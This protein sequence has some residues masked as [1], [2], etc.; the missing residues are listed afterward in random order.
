MNSIIYNLKRTHIHFALFVLM[1]FAVTG[2][3][4]QDEP[5]DPRF[6]R[7]PQWY[8]DLKRDAPIMPSTVVTINDYDNFYLGVDFAEGHISE[9]PRN[10]MQYF[11]AF[12]INNTHHTENGHDWSTNNPSW[13]GGVW[14]DPVTAYDSLGNLYYENMYG[15]GTIQGCKVV[16]STDN[17]QTWGPPVIAI[18]GVD[19]NWIAADQTNGPYANYVYTVMTASSGG[20][21]TRSTDYGASFQ[22]MW[23]FP[24]QSLPGMMVAVGAHDNIQGG[25]VYVVTNGGSVSAST[26]TFY[27]SLN[28]GQ[29]FTQMSSQ[30]WAGY[31]GTFVNGRHSVQNMRTRPYPFIAADNSFG[32][33]RGRLYCVYATNDPP[34]SGNKPDILSRYSDDGG[35]T[36]SAAVRVNDDANTQ[37]HHQW[38]PAIWCDKDNGKLYVQWMDT[39]DTPNSDSCYIYATY[40]DDGG[41][42]F[43]TNQRISNEKMKI[44]CTTCGGSGTPRYQ[45]DYNAIVSNSKVA[46][47]TWADYRYGSFASFTAYFPDFALR[48]SPENIAFS[49]SDTL[50]VTV[51]SVKL[52]TDQ[53]LV[54]TSIEQPQ[55]GSISFSYPNG[56]VINNVPGSLPVVFTSNNAPVGDYGFTITAK[57]PNGTP[58]HTR[59]GTI[60]ILPGEPPVA[61]FSA[62]TTSLCAG[63]V[64]NFF[65]QSTNS[66]TSWEWSFPGG[67]PDTSTLKDPEN[68]LYVVPGKYDVSLKVTNALGSDS[69]TST[70]YITV[71]F[72]PEPPVTTGDT[73]LCH[74]EEVPDLEAEGENIAWYDDPEL[75]NLVHEGNVFSTGITEPGS[76]TF[77]VTQTVGDCPSEPSTV[78][79]TIHSLPEVY[80]APLMPVCVDA[81]PV[82]LTGG[83]PEGGTYVGEGVIEG[84]FYPEI[85]GVGSFPIT[86]VY[87]DENDCSDESTQL[88][89]VN[90]LPVI[91]LGGA[92]SICEGESYTFDAGPGFAVYL[93][94]DGSS[95]QTL[96]VSEAGQYWVSVTNIYGCTASDTAELAVDPFPGKAAIPGGETVVDLYFGTVTTYTT[97]GADFAAHY[98][99]MLDPPTSGSISGTGLTGTVEWNNGFTG[100]ATVSVMAANDCGEGEPSDTLTVQVYSTQGI[101]DNQIGEIAIYPNPSQGIFTLKISTDRV[102]DLNIHITNMLGETIFRQENVRADGAF[103][104]QISLENV[105]SGMMILKIEDGNDSWTGKVFIS[106]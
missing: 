29:T 33:Y 94:N 59:T 103:T 70:E 18:A 84:V 24:T 10:P 27:R 50:T 61:S 95:E 1:A 6:D 36:W 19:K 88:M 7:I 102:K 20:N 32:P 38:M 2:A 100:T 83:M 51:P 16:V 49:T 3:M 82:T 96:T 8:I 23:Y 64:V 54:L 41:V 13:G 43:K 22:Q 87:T 91:D 55:T 60:S 17:G 69:I 68:I 80:F 93:W 67:E 34:G 89:D 45:G 4:S 62:D 98:A 97:L 86:Y 74:G 76:Y 5:D 44:N 78:V 28:G 106:P 21:L 92:L 15:G 72:T 105:K 25:A 12:N 53:V 48:I 14:G 63:G 65:D 85:A 52:Y 101:A 46:K 35:A 81:G 58:V 26:Y 73:A 42:T 40:S 30:Q 11:A 39:R 90:P 9:N 31:V 75:T 37:Q 99:W 66:P 104:R 57:G 71:F 56:F 47:A 79:L 77:Y